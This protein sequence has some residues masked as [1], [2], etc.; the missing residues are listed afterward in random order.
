MDFGNF[1]RRLNLPTAQLQQPQPV[2]QKKK[3]PGWTA[4]MSEIGGTGGALGGALGGAAIGSVVPGIGTAIGGLIGGGLGAFLGGTGGSAAEQKVRDNKV[5]LGKALKEGAV[6][7]IL[8]AGPLKL[9]KAAFA[10]GKALK[11]SQGTKGALQAVRESVEKPGLLSR[12]GATL[13]GEARGIGIG[14]KVAGSRI[15]PERVG[16]INKFLESTVKIGRGSS[17]KQLEKLEPFI[18]NQNETLSQAISKSNRPLTDADKK[19]ILDTFQNNFSKSIIGATPRQQAIADDLLT[20]VNQST[21]IRSLDDLRKIV[22][23]NINFARNAASPEPA[24]E[25]V[26][27]AFRRILTDDVANKVGAAKS[28][29]S[30]LANAF[31]AQELILN[32]AAKPGSGISPAGI[33]L[34]GRAT[35]SLQSNSGSLVGGLGRALESRGP[36][37]T[38]VRVATGSTIANPP[39]LQQPQS[40]GLEEALTQPQDPA[41]SGEIMNPG[42]QM[43]DQGAQQQSP[44]SQEA[45]MYDIQRDPANADNY[46]AY[47]QQ[48]QE[49]YA[50]PEEKPLSA[51]ASKVISNANSGLQSLGQLETL[52]GQDPSVRQKTVVP[53]RS[54]FGGAGASLLG[55]SSYDTA[56][57]NIADVITRLRTGAALTESEEKFYLSQL[58]QAFD[59]EETV[60]QKLNMFRDLFTSVA[61]RSGTAGTDVE[62][63]VGY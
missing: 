21:D 4:W 7:G 28:L 52:L 43:L 10:G 48:L 45:L 46:L 59:P 2:Q 15:G 55:T 60:Q 25:Q 11:A 41:L 13:R 49:V 57:R 5:D 38:G 63:A 37:A 17:A 30:N 56:A 40:A 27:K 62:A 20:R 6:E 12:T 58:P 33:T 50:V 1:D 54:L 14:E 3:K 16:D 47:Y 29:K 51:E 23:D 26:Y 19:G 61:N 35:Q 31:E 44:Y 22:D 24:A 32:R 53:G 9:G 8:S 42:G 39:L 18:K 34:P 36:L